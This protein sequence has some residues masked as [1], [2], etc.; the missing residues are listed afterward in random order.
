M[1]S[2]LASSEKDILSLAYTD[3]SQGHTTLDEKSGAKIPARRWASKPSKHRL[4]GFL[5]TAIVLII[6]LGFVALILG[7]LLRMQYV[8]VQ[9]GRG[10]SAAVKHGSFA[11]DEE[12]WSDDTSSGGHLRVLILSALASH[13]IS[14][15]SSILMTLVAYRVGAQW[16][17]VSKEGDTTGIAQNPTP[18]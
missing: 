18:L 2:L 13:L 3:G 4:V 17:R 9:G 10:L 16:L 12:E 7:F 6:T 5:P 1:A 15:T 11:L 14:D 8:P